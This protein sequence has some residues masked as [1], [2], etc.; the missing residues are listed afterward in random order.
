MTNESSILRIVK[1][2]ILRNLAE[3]EDR[4]NIS[5]IN[6]KVNV[7]SF[8][9]SKALKELEKEKLIKNE[10]DLII[11]TVDGQ[12]KSKNILRKHLIL[13]NYF[14][15]TLDEVTAH[16]KAHIL[17]HYVSEEVIKNIKKMHTLRDNAIPSTNISLRKEGLIADINIIK[18]HNL[19]ERLVSMGIFPGN[20]IEILA[21]ISGIFVVKIGNKKFAL[22]QEIAEEIK[23]L[24]K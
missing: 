11:L 16:R 17:E 22:A 3:R 23:I 10:K 9:I 7:S 24:E 6:S 13:E 15:K 19:F 4:L 20:R 5:S 21:I 8:L 18:N 1:E 14:K 12:E 2:D